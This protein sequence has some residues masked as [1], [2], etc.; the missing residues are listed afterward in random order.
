MVKDLIRYLPYS[1]C[2][3]ILLFSMW[4]PANKQLHSCI[5]WKDFNCM[6]FPFQ[7]QLKRQ[8]KWRK[9]KKA[10]EEKPESSKR[11]PIS[12]EI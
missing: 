2:F 9:L 5:S 10:E 3:K 1:D 4:G 12:A 7:G 6:S 8:F 11:L